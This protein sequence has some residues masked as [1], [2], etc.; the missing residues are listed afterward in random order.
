VSKKTHD[1]FISYVEEDSVEAVA[2]AN[3]LE[4]ASITTWYYERDCLPG[5]DYFKEI[6]ESIDSACAVLV[7]ISPDS[8][9]SNQVKN[10]ITYAH[11]NNKPFIPILKDITHSE[12]QK[13]QPGWR[14]A[15]GSYTSIMF[16][17]GNVGSIIDRVVRGTHTLINK[18]LDESNTHSLTKSDEKIYNSIFVSYAMQD[19]QKVLSILRGMQMIVPNMKISGDFL[20][21]KSNKNW[22]IE[23]ENQIKACDVFYLFWSVAAMQS[24]WVKTEL[25]LA[26]AY[27]GLEGIIPIPLDPPIIAP[28]PAGLMSLNFSYNPLISLQSNNYYK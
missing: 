16:S 6:I 4:K 18:K 7:L 26:L 24:K 13:R 28:P 20:S 2:L 14:M 25:Q 23:I 22:D 10:E 19:S 21:L 15:L 3:G 27:K 12:Y 11:E 1:V 9:S 17:D 8:L 5:L